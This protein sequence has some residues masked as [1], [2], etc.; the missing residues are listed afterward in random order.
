MESRG[1]HGS[2]KFR[3]KL[4]YAIVATVLAGCSTG[5]TGVVTKSL[6][7]TGSPAA[8]PIETYARIA[9]GANMCWF[10]ASG[11]LRSSH[12]FQADVKPA[13]EGGLAEIAIHERVSGQS[14]PLG[15]VA[16]R[17][18]IKGSETHSEVTTENIRMP[19]AMALTMRSDIEAWH[20]GSSTC[21][22]EQAK[23]PSASGAARAGAGR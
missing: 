6:Q 5:P 10:G 17:I 9:R 18:H 14:S 12:I 16:Y 7:S 13:S 20:S 8:A 21:M 23:H 1:L 2:L 3:L 19:E 15:Y 22:T 4:T 11:T